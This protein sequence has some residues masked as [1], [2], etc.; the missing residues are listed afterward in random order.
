MLASARYC[1]AMKTAAPV[2]SPQCTIVQL[3][4][5]QLHDDETLRWR[6]PLRGFTLEENVNKQSTVRQKRQDL[7]IP[8]L[9]IKGHI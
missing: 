1:C 6:H 3:H 7:T 2:C 4:L 9:V 8:W 5:R